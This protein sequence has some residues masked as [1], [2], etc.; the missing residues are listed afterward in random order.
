[1]TIFSS[2]YELNKNGFVLFSGL[3]VFLFYCRARSHLELVRD[4]MIGRRIHLLT[5]NV[6]ILSIIFGN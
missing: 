3:I 2:A 6:G 1:V 4:D 5:L